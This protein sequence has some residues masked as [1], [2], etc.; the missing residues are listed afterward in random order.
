MC[1]ERAQI[2][3]MFD[4]ICDVSELSLSS[5]V[6]AGGWGNWLCK[7]NCLPSYY[8]VKTFQNHCRV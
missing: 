4:V 7:V 8:I 6:S 2:Q 1:L 5:K 3:A